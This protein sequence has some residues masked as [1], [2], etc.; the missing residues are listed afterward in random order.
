MVCLIMELPSLLLDFAFR[1]PSKIAFAS[2]FV[3]APPLF[4][5]VALDI[6]K[7]SLFPSLLSCVPLTCLLLC[8]LQR[9]DILLRHAAVLQRRFY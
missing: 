3:S 4:Y 9:L 2:C 6:L 8:L 1:C 5:G 7:G